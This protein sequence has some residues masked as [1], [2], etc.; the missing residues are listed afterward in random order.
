MSSDDDT[1][2]LP[3][4]YVKALQAFRAIDEDAAAPP[5]PV[6]ISRGSTTTSSSSSYKSSS[7][8]SSEPADS[9][10]ERRQRR[11]REA[12][13][14]FLKCV[15]MIESL[16]LFSGNEDMDDLKTNEIKYLLVP[17]YLGAVHQQVMDT[18]LPGPEGRLDPLRESKKCFL[19]FLRKADSLECGLISK[20]DRKCMESEGKRE[21]GMS[22]EA[23]RALKISRAKRE[24]QIKAETGN[25][26]RS[27]LEKLRMR[28]LESDSLEDEEAENEQ[29]GTY[30]EEF[31]RAKAMF[32]LQSFVIKTLNELECL[33]TELDMLETIASMKPKERAPPPAGPSKFK[34][35]TIDTRIPNGG[36]IPSQEMFDQL[37]PNVRMANVPNG[38]WN[39]DGAMKQLS[40]DRKDMFKPGWEQPTVTIE[41][42]GEA[43]MRYIHEQERIKAQM[44]FENGDIVQHH[45]H[46]GSCLDGVGGCGSREVV[47]D[48][49]DK[50]LNEDDDIDNEAERTKTKEWDEF[51]DDNPTGWGNTGANTG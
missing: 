18:Q 38:M 2:T 32:Q 40:I 6:T 47:A 1:L 46:M 12:L 42:A 4:L 26:I 5:Q 9:P 14:M 35:F 25:M 33:H 34:N 13:A 31:E 43:D 51:C 39:M 36:G 50:G 16:S 15:S 41:E 37:P 48:E 10:I 20:E 17:Y 11:V 22:G 29:D 30:D 23:V 45:Q 49:D 7:S 3:S 24:N 19:S 44:A 8:R 21:K 28:R 27:H